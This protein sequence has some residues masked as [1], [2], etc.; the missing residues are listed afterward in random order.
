MSQALYRKWRP[1]RFDQVIGQE[2]VTRTLQAAVAADRVGHAYLFC[3]PRGTGKTTMARLLA[4]AVNCEAADPAARPDDTCPLC[5]AVNEGRFLD[6]IEIDAASNTGVDDIRT[7]RE[8]VNF[9]PSQGRY[10]VYIIDEVHMLSIAAFNALLKTLEEPPAHTIFVLA[11]TEEHK[12]P[13]T[14]KSRCQQFNFRLLTTPEIAARL[15]WL[16]GQETLAIESGAVE[17]LARQASGSL[18]DA[19]SLLDQLVVSPDDRITLERAQLVLGTA[20]DAAVLAVVDAWLD[21]DSARGLGVIHDAL[22][23]GA[24]ARQFCRQMVA[25]LRQLLLLQVAGAQ[26]DVEGPVERKAEMLAQAGRA[27][28]R[29]LIDAVRRFQE[30]ALQPTGSWQPQLPLELAFIELLPD[31][32]MQVAWVGERPPQAEGRRTTDD[33]RPPQIEERPLTA[34]RRPPPAE[35]RQPAAE[36][37]PAQAEER[38]PAAVRPP[39]P[40][41]ALTVAAVAGMWP[42]MTQQVGRQNKNLPAL[43]TMCKPLAIEGRT[44]ILGFDYPLLK[45]KFDKT[46]GAADLVVAAFRALSGTD[47]LIRTVAT[48]DYPVPIHRDEFQALAAELGGVVRDDE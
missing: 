44:I 23:S 45:D 13:V 3:G 47:C 10:K 21:A 38:P 36:R 29:A 19:E 46:Q 1:A 2:H 31:A 40:T 18:R 15:N 24:D 28:R 9:A 12:V 30:A 48:A 17:L 11:T 41:A 5:R 7:L 37:R 33:G 27:P 26:L 34:D 14:I 25:H 39:T 4:K 20:P 16:A 43:L 42:E 22:A 32:P 6:L 35:E 8:K